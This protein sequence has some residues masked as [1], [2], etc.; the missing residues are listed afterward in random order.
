MKNQKMNGLTVG[1]LFGALSTVAN[2]LTVE[3]DKTLMPD[4]LAEGRVLL[5]YAGDKVSSMFVQSNDEVVMTG[6]PIAVAEDAGL[7]FACPA[8]TFSNAVV[9]VGTVC[10]SNHVASLFWNDIVTQ[11]ETLLFPNASLQAMTGVGALSHGSQFAEMTLT[12]YFVERGDTWWESQMQAKEGVALKGFLFRMEEKPDGVYGKI[13]WAHY[14]SNV[15]LGSSLDVPE[16]VDKTVSTTMGGYAYGMKD[17]TLTYCL[18]PSPIVTFTQPVDCGTISVAAG[19]ARF[20]SACCQFPAVIPALDVNAD[21]S[22]TLVVGEEVLPLGNPITGSGKIVFE[23]DG[24]LDIPHTVQRDTYVPTANAPAVLTANGRLTTITDIAAR[25]NGTNMRPQDFKNPD[26][27]PNPD[28]NATVCHYENDGNAATCQL[29]IREGSLLKCVQLW[30]QQVGVSITVSTTAAAYGTYDAE[31]FPVGRKFKFKNVDGEKTAT[32]GASGYGVEHLT[33]EGIRSNFIVRQS[34]TF[35][36]AGM[37]GGSYD[38]ANCVLEVASQTGLPPTGAVNV[39]SNGMLSVQTA[40]NPWSGGNS[41]PLVSISVHSGTLN[42]D[43]VEH[44]LG[45]DPQKPLL[46]DGCTVQLATRNYFNK[47]VF[48]NGVEMVSR[49]NGTVWVGGNTGGVTTW[50]VCGNAPTTISV[51]FQTVGYKISDG[52]IKTHEFNVDDVTGDAAADLVF[53][54]DW[55]PYSDM[56]RFEVVKTGAG[57][58]AMNAQLKTPFPKPIRVEGGT[59]LLGVSD[60]MSA[61]VGIETVGAAIAVAANT[62]NTISSVKLSGNSTIEVEENACLTLTTLDLSEATQ[63]VLAGNLRKGF[64]Y[65]PRLS[66]AELAKFVDAEGA[67]IQQRPDGRLRGSMNGLILT[68]H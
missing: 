5:T 1:L 12:P 60:V 46:L 53:G 38:I 49:Q 64:L 25:L 33:V 58:L 23:G 62:T 29:Q 26:G 3:W 66:A 6:D 13:L 20:E 44:G 24:A 55:S 56:T 51:P 48:S 27:S 14:I 35:T 28:G 41:G 9:A 36:A 32:A 4:S 67:P 47:T 57:T 2:P 8:F 50:K 19:C 31:T 34:D 42:L 18:Y 65:A 68:V 16:A 54:T 61:E 10:I 37:T 43:E 45:R 15:P 40:G 39:W 63:V 7:C 22:V 59:W 11:K 21:A 52:L 17:V 30:F